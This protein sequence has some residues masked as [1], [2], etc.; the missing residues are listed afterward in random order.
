MEKQELLDQYKYIIELSGIKLLA[1]DSLGNPFEISSLVVALIAMTIS[2][3]DIDE[4]ERAAMLCGWINSF[5]DEGVN[6]TTVN[7][8]LN[9]R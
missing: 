2:R 4:A 8:P 3:T 1:T 9:D 6:L 5:A 7:E